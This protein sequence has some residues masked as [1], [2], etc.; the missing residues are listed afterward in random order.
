MEVRDVI[1]QL[2]VPDGT[3]LDAIVPGILTTLTREMIDAEY[4]WWLP[5]LAAP[6]ARPPR[7]RT[8]APRVRTGPREHNARGRHRAAYAR[9]QRSFTAS[10]KRCARNVLSA[11]WEEEPSP[12]PIALQEPYW[13]AV[14]QQP[15]TERT[16]AVVPGFPHYRGGPYQGN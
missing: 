10:R 14:F 3:D 15:S 12:V 6:K 8:R 11:T 9:T 13:R 16:Y 4:A 7:R 2:G 1:Y 5:P